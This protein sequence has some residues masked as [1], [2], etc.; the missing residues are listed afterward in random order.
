MN[1]HEY[2]KQTYQRFL[3]TCE[4]MTENLLYGSKEKLLA[5]SQN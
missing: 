3:E 4:D 2:K 5:Y 1:Q